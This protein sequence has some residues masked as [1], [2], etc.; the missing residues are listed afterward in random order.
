MNRSLLFPLICG[1]EMM[2]QIAIIFVGKSPFH[3]VNDG[4][5]LEQWGICIGFSAVTFVVSFFVKL[6]PIHTCIDNYLEAKMKK[7]EEI[8][9]E[10]KENENDKN[11][12]NDEVKLIKFENGST[13]KSKI[14]M[15]KVSNK[16]LFQEVNED[17]LV[18]SE[19]NGGGGGGITDHAL[20]NREGTNK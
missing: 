9:N 18:L 12:K 14:K 15:G 7:E 20:F 19:H 16:N 2:L 1:V 4:L 6:L 8:E 11:D 3:V 17:S 5:T 10:E 13:E